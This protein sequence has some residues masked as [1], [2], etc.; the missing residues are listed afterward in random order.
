MDGDIIV[1]S[2]IN[3][4]ATF[5]LSL[6]LKQVAKIN[7]FEPKVLVSPVKNFKKIDVLV[8]E[9]SITNSAVLCD[10]LEGMGH[11]VSRAMNGLEALD[12]AKKQ[13]FDIIFMDINMPIMDGIE[14]S[15]KIRSGGGLNSKTYIVGLTAHASDEFGVEAEQAGMDCYFTKPIRLVAL[16]KIISDVVSGCPLEAI[17]E[18]SLVLK[19]LFETLGCE[20][21]LEVSQIF[22]EELKQFIE[23]CNQGI[24]SQDNHAL[25]EVA[26]K[27]KGSAAMLGLD[28]LEKLF[29]QLEIDARVDNVRDLTNRIQS[30][31]YIAKHSEAMVVNYV[32]LI[33]K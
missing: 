23:Q 4:G 27:I 32:S 6:P 2:N 11:K 16:Q 17:G 8:V 15:Q 29:S 20:K 10:M 21:A 19:E 7:V 13:I 12:K 3:E 26:H 28:L 18:F 5:I 33:V 1:E 14:A 24:F 25:A 31:K 30:L 9:D 22:F